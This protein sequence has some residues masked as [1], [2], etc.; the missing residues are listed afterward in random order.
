[1]Q[2]ENLLPGDK[3]LYYS[4]DKKIGKYQFIFI[5]QKHK[6]SE[7]VSFMQLPRRYCD[8]DACRN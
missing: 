4:G 3:G 2:G 1:M 7:K 6:S 5:K 8:P